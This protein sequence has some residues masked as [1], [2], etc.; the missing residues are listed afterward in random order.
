MDADKESMK[1]GGACCEKAVF[2]LRM[3]IGRWLS[4]RGR[5]ELKQSVVCEGKDQVGLWDSLQ[6]GSPWS[7]VSECYFTKREDIVQVWRL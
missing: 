5:E 4:W 3:M 1:E 6:S 2:R 7:L